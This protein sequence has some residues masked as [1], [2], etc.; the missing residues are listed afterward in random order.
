MSWIRRR[1][2]RA[3]TRMTERTRDSLRR[4][5]GVKLQGDTLVRLDGR[6]TK[7]DFQ[8][9]NQMQ[10][11]V[12]VNYCPK[13]Q[14]Q[15]VILSRLDGGRVHII[16]AHFKDFVDLKDYVRHLKDRFG[17]RPVI[18]DAGPSDRQF[19]EDFD[20]ERERLGGLE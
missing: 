5:L 1:W 15:I 20:M 6:L 14:S 17:D 18:L 3:K 2:N 12:D 4:F 7:L 13:E 16:S 8:L 10:I 9:S 11:G 19:F